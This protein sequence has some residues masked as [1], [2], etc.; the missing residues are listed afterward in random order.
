MR[1]TVIGSI[2]VVFLVLGGEFSPAAAQAGP[3]AQSQVVQVVT[4]LFD[5]M[6]SR[7]TAAIRSVFEPTA[8]LLGVSG[9]GAV[10]ATTVDQ[11]VRSIGA[12]PADVELIE[13]IYSP[14]VRIDGPVAQVWTFYTFHRGE[15]FSH[16]GIDAVQLLKVAEGWKIV[17]LADTR[18]TENCEPPGG[19]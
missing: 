12:A 14:E 6:Q 7:D 16:C 10:R 8:R 4:K 3:D 19:G 1:K 18:R 9:S 2:A 5:G 17:S 11:F 15:Q 13:R